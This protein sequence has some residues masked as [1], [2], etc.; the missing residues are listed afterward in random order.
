MGR[1]ANSVDRILSLL[2][3]KDDNGCWN[4]TG[5]LAKNGYGHMTLR[6]QFWLV[7]RFFYTHF[8]GGIA[9]GLTIDHLCRNRAC[10]NPEHLDAV[11]QRENSLRAP[12]SW[13]AIN[14][15]K[16][17]CVQGHPLAGGNLYVTPD[18]RR[19]CR[20]CRREAVT[21]SRQKKAA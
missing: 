18:G 5:K 17:K 3:R 19:Q 10:C 6:G 21:R 20:T 9:P 2:V 11:T 12:S 8:K 1:P 15:A 14:V 16:T 4:Y 7:H 13:N